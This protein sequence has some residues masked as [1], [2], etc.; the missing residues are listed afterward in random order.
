MTQ[1]L[2]GTSSGESLVTPVPEEA[3]EPAKAQEAEVAA[4]TVL[5]AEAPASTAV[6][7]S[8]EEPAGAVEA[9]GLSPVE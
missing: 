6:A 1:P 9:C 8:L 2:E 7:S 3:S 5:E 4:E